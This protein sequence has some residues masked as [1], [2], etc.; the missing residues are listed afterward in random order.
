M[1]K[2]IRG[3][4]KLPTRLTNPITV[5]NLSLCTF[6]DTGNRYYLLELGNPRN[7]DNVLVRIDSKC[8]YAHIF[9]SAR[10]DCAEQLH[11]AMQMI[12]D[13]GEGLLIFAYDQDGR[14]ISL[15]DHMTVYQKQDEGLDTVE[16][17][18]AVGL[19]AD[20]RDYAEVID[21]LKD[22]G[23]ANIRLLTNNPQ[24]LK[25]LPEAGINITRIPHKVVEL[26]KYNAAQLMVKQT[27]LGH[28]FNWDLEKNKDLFEQ[29]LK[30][31]DW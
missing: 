26:D 30:Q 8:V 7:K 16:A 20:Q 12:A 31:I 6:K 14:G 11:T 5:F 15:P 24:R 13:E 27:K 22:Y 1:E 29:S 19:R 18:E 3:S 2:E 4:M 23:L 25:D 10:C 21:I 28:L 17:N 9:G